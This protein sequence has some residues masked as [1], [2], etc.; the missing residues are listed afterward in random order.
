MTSQST[1]SP[2]DISLHQLKIF[3]AVADAATLTEAAKQLGI[4]QPSLSQQLSRL[5]TLV[6]ARLFNRRPGEMELTEAGR[7]L[8]PKAEHILRGMRDLEDGLMEYTFGRRM[9]IRLAGI[10]SV[11][12]VLLPPALRRLQA[13]FPDVDF[14]IQ[15]M[16]PSDI[17]ELLYDRRIAVG[18]FAD[19]SLMA[20]GGG[21][22]QIPLLT[23]SHV[24][25][26]PAHLD[27]SQ[28][29]NPERELPSEAFAVLNQSIQFAFGSQHTKRVQNW[30]ERL[31]PSYTIVAQCRSFEVAAELVRAGAGVCLVPALSLLHG[32]ETLK[33][34]RLYA[35]NS[36]PRHII[37][38]LPTQY[39]H[40]EPYRTFLD[41]LKDAASTIVLPEV[42]PIPPFLDG[43]PQAKF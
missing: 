39:Q 2:L 29:K 25:A 1:K 22:A 37:A 19:N 34:I 43:G 6:G 42:L 30:Y 13:I 36:A 40:A 32:A 16:A 21:F 7:Y 31:L 8:L 35:V 17:I 24:L 9:T 33:G 12:R 26:V 3:T 28:I 4:A 15:D 20:A 38:L 18:L 10:T 11:L 14:D 27:L 23:D 5:E 41:T